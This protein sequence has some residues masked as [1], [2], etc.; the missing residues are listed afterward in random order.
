VNGYNAAMTPLYTA[1]NSHFAFQLRWSIA[2]FWQQPVSTDPW[3]AD[4]Q[5]ATDPDNV[6]LLE[7]R[8]IGPTTSQFLISTTP[9]VSPAQLLRT[10]K[11]RLQHLVRSERP[12]AFRRNYSLHSVGDANV[13]AIESYVARQTSHHPMADPRV[14]ASVA[15]V[16][17]DEPTVDLATV[18]RSAHGEFHYNL[19]VVI[20]REERHPIIDPSFLEATRARLLAAAAKH[21]H[22]LRRAGILAD[23]VHLAIGCGIAESPEEVALSYLNNLA[24]LEDMRPVFQFGSYLGTFGNYDMAAVRR[25]RDFSRPVSAPPA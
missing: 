4:L 21:G 19:H 10:V 16:Q 24:H 3:F 23:H 8:F 1:A 15:A 20:V 13:A 22:L 6:R 17:I 11:G 18:R 25:S 5:A 9:E 7:H 2:I 12:K 14:Q